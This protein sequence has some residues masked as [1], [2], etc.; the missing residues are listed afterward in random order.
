MT[1]V[2]RLSRLFRA[3]ANAVLDRIEEPGVLLRQAVREMEQSLADDEQRLR[4]LTHAQQLQTSRLTE[5][6]QSLGELAG[7][8]DTCFR[9]DRDDLARA[10]IRRRLECEQVRRLATARR[11]GLAHQVAVLDERIAANRQRLLAMRQKAEALIEEDDGASDDQWPGSGVVVRDEDVEV[12]LL[13]E[14]QRRKQS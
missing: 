4:R 2:T 11:D 10:L 14:K 13:Q 1:L 6:E 3:D 5:V 12:A 8:L 9:S 7:Q